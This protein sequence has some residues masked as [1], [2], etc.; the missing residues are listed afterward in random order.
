MRARALA[1][2]AGLVAAWCTGC[3]TTQTE[4]PPRAITSY[5]ALGDTFAAAPGTSRTK[6]AS[7]CRRARKNY[8][9]QVA[10]TLGVTSFKDVSCTSA[11]DSAVTKRMTAG[12]HRIDPQ[13]SAVDSSTD[14]VTV[15]FGA[16][17][18]DL[19]DKI[20][21]ACAPRSTYGC[22]LAA[23]APTVLAHIQQVRQTL[24]TA[25]R[26]INAKAPSA[27]V[28]VV[29]YPRHLDGKQ[30]CKG[31]PTMAAVDRSA[32]QQ[33]DEA[34]NVAASRAARDTGAAFADVYA[35]SKGHGVCSSQPWVL[36]AKPERGIG[37]ALGPTAAGET[38]IAELIHSALADDPTLA[39]D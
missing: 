17:A 32:W 28:L 1:V 18:Y 19:Y 3:G 7:G 10:H 8:P 12:R 13:I 14:L 9:A 16:Y 36:P 29:G 30:T 5:V 20:A 2:V 23:A 33:I 38:A 35:A 11:D 22:R 25:I 34:L 26:A 15:Q 37:V 39:V 27:Y 6:P 4:A 31:L 24:A 21:L